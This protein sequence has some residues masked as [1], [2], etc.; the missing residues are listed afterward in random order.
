MKRKFSH[1]MMFKRT[2]A[3]IYIASGIF[4]LLMVLSNV[5]AETRQVD[6]YSDEIEVIDCMNCDEID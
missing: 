1:E 4:V 5:R 3:I 6:S 2:L